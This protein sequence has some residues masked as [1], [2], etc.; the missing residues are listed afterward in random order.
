MLQR[1]EAQGVGVVLH[2]GRGH[3]PETSPGLP[4]H[5]VSTAV[6]SSP[7]GGGTGKASPSPRHNVSGTSTSRCGVSCNVEP[8]WNT[9]RAFTPDMN[10]KA[11][12][13]TK[14]KLDV[15]LGCKTEGGTPR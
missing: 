8:S 4:Q 2:E 13:G 14:A 6:T 5:A 12:A 15:V 3:L 7:D 11:V 9:Y 1:G 10:V